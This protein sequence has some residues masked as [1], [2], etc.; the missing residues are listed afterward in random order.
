M[1]EKMPMPETKAFIDT[2]VFLYL[3]SSDIEKADQAESVLQS[4]GIISVQV[5]NELVNVAR[6]QLALPWEE[7]NEFLYLIR[8][9]CLT[10]PLTLETHSKGV[11]IAERYG[12]SVYDAMIVAAALVAGCQVL[13]SEDMQD[14]QQID[15]QLQIS[16]PFSK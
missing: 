3:L 7:I 13:Y 10:E 8:S 4:G 11:Y 1:T 15:Y 6:R 9:L 14:G 2:N 16:N 5:L 12:F